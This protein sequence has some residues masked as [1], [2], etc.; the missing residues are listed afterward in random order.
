M[1]EVTGV[2]LDPGVILII[3]I[4][5]RETVIIIIIIIVREAGR[6]PRCTTTVRIAPM[7]FF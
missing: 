4:S 5:I 1:G 6:R 3:I 7:T 2:R